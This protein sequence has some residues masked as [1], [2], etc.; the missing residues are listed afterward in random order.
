M[1]TS[2]VL[3]GTVG[4]ACADDVQINTPPG[5]S[6]V[7]KDNAGANTR[8]KV[9]GSGPVT[10][11]NL[12]GAPA[13][14]GAVCFDPAGT[15]G[16]CTGRPQIICRS[17]SQLVPCNSPSPCTGIDI[18]VNA[19]CPDGFMRLALQYCEKPS[20]LNLQAEMVF[21]LFHIDDHYIGCRYR[22]AIDPFRTETFG[23]TIWCIERNPYCF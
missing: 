3:A 9:D 12:A 1:I 21:P 4:A 11:P 16:K 2:L 14:S 15:L 19:T 8:L 7:V 17:E 13:Y 18:T 20:S 22:G 10:V 5:G 23:L 6:F